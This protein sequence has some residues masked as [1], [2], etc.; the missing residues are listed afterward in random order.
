MQLKEVRVCFGSPLEVTWESHIAA[1]V[2]GSWPHCIY[3]EEREG[4]ECLSCLTSHSLYSLGNGCAYSG[5]VLPP[6]L[7]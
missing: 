4:S 5:K 7:N 2:G 3:S 6:Q 1:G